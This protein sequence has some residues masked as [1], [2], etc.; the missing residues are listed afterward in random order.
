MIPY[1]AYP[2][3]DYFHV[4]FV[5]LCRPYR[6]CY[7]TI[8]AA[9]GSTSDVACMMSIPRISLNIQYMLMLVMVQM[10]CFMFVRFWNEITLFSATEGYASESVW[11][12]LGYLS[13][14]PV[15][16]T[17]ERTVILP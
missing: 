11:I 17:G 7:L 3:G 16:G 2:T 5:T 15:C 4:K 6:H 10:V 14:S 12:L 9:R 1:A 8:V 13:L